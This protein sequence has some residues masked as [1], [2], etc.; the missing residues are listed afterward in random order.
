ML[1]R[2]MPPLHRGE[3]VGL[4]PDRHTFQL[5]AYTEM[6]VQNFRAKALTWWFVGS[7]TTIV[8][9]VV[10][11]NIGKSIADNNGRSR[12][13]PNNMPSFHYVSTNKK[14]YILC[15]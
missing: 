1:L 2:K 8:D 7:S 4:T 9:C 12:S 15:F 11:A 6:R 13:V 5:K 14:P 10:P 3:L